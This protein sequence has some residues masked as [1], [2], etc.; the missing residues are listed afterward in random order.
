MAAEKGVE[1]TRDSANRIA[2]VVRQVE[3]GNRRSN[4]LF[5]EP[6]L[7]HF[8]RSL[9][10]GMFTGS[11][12]VETAKAVRVLPGTATTVVYNYCVPVPESPS[13][14]E[15]RF[16]IFGKV[17]LHNEN[18]GPQSIVEVQI[19][20]TNETCANSINGISLEDF[21]D[22]AAGDVQLLAHDGSAC[23]KWVS[24]TTCAT[25]EVTVPDEYGWFY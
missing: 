1:F 13:T 7:Q 3:A 11:W 21:P 5:L 16:V 15:E 17:Q 2:K 6:R 14:T 22:Y 8:P 9:T 25:T 10:L 18:I 23:L 20:S 24:V 4:G 12:D 19:Q